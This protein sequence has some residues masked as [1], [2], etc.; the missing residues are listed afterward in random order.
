MVTQKELNNLDPEF[1][2]LSTWLT[3]VEAGR[4]WFPIVK[5]RR[6][7]LI[8]KYTV[9]RGKKQGGVMVGRKEAYTLTRKGRQMLNTLRS[10]GY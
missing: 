2:D 6:N 9:R 7:G 10:M 5:L 1:R 8:K 3:R 4:G